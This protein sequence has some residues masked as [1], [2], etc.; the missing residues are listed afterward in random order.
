MKGALIPKM[1]GIRTAEASEGLRVMVKVMNGDYRSPVDEP[2]TYR[3]LQGRPLLP[4][5]LKQVKP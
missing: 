2:Q 3:P 1:L 5:E 4:S